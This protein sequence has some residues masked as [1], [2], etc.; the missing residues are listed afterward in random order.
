V[1]WRMNKRFVGIEVAPGA[2]RLAEIEHG[3]SGWTLR[4]WASVALPEGA[5]KPSFK[6]PNVAEPRAFLAAAQDLLKRHTG[7]VATVGLSLPSEIIRVLIRSYP[8]LPKS[9]A[10]TERLINWSLEKSFHFPIENTR[11]SFHAVGADGNGI[12]NLLVTIGMREVIRQFEDLLGELGITTRVVR[13]AGINLFN[14]YA[15]LLP[16]TGTHAFMGL[17]DN[18]F[19]FLVFENTRLSFFHGVK[20]G[21]ADLQ[22]FQDVDL[23]LQHY[24]DLNPGKRIEQLCVGSQVGYHDELREVL[25]NLI[26]VKIKVLNESELIDAPF[27]TQNPVER[28]KLASLAS[29]VGAAQGLQH[30]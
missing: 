15:P 21:F 3:A 16:D 4:Q 28:L 7:G 12:E 5:V 23:T 10:E 29:A 14:F 1:I 19:N 13:P 25:G 6:T 8:R 17:F 24:L 20:R 30:V 27:E 2:M 9:R 26:D 11:V 22:F 18:Y